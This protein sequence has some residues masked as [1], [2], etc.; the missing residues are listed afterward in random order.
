[1]SHHTSTVPHGQHSYPEHVSLDDALQQPKKYLTGKLFVPPKTMSHSFVENKFLGHRDIVITNLYDRNRA[2]CYDEVVVELYP[3]TEWV[4]FSKMKQKQQQHQQDDEQEEDK[5]PQ[6]P[7]DD[8]HSDVRVLQELWEPNEHLLESYRTPV[9]DENEKQ[10]QEFIEEI[11][12]Q[13]DKL[14][15]QPRGKVVA[16][17]PSKS[18]QSRVL[19]GTISWEVPEEIHPD[20]HGDNQSAHHGHHKKSR[21]HQGEPSKEEPLLLFHPDDLRYLPMIVPQRFPYEASVS[22]KASI[23]DWPASSKYPHCKDLER[24]E[25]HGSM[26]AELDDLLKNY[27]VHTGLSS[28]FPL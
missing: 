17:L 18:L 10:Q 1:M 13:S 16:I 25:S 26:E 24:N 8:L 15:L 2:N 23:G 9:L 12:Q 28:L 4:P 19:T 20:S 3:I 27:T 11:I 5:N 7:E 14:H 22:Y 21:G 6:S